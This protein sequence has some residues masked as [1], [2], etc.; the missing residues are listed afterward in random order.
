MSVGVKAKLQPSIGHAIETAKSLE[1]STGVGTATTIRKELEGGKLDLD[2]YGRARF[3]V[4]Y[5]A[6]LDVAAAQ[7]EMPADAYRG[8]HLSEAKDL[9]AEVTGLLRRSSFTEAWKQQGFNYAVATKLT[10]VLF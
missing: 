6:A 4:D 9:L 7:G 2:T 8:P 10:G 5:V 3:L 1:Q